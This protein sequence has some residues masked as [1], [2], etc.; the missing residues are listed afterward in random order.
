VIPENIMITT[1]EQRRQ[2]EED[3]FL[4][5]RRLFNAEEIAG[6]RADMPALNTEQLVAEAGGRNKGG[7]V[8]EDNNTPRLQFDFHRT[9]T[10]F[11]LLARHP[12]T[13]GIVQEVIGVPMYIYHSKLAF[14]AAF[15]GSV[16]FWHQDYGYWVGSKH[17][18]PLMASCFVMLEPHTEDNG[19]M[20]VL[21][22]SH[23][24]GVVPHE[25]C[26]RESTGDSQIR[27]P[28]S[29]MVEYC[30]RYQRIK[31][32]GEAGDFV[33]WHSNTMHAS[34]H[35]ISD[36]SRHSAIIAYNAVGNYDPEH[37]TGGRSPWGAECDTPVDLCAD[38]ALRQ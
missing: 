32:I 31:L 34:A 12:R 30:K 38:N 1:P 14:K 6:L 11:S 23:R 4:I 5:I 29:A 27:I 19:C 7:M 9:E 2:F 36:R 10:R 26:P 3:G 16:Q 18:K 37:R 25:P 17:P 33:V 13:A 24:E 21:A 28:S 22:R 35:N 20:Q 15:T 8:V